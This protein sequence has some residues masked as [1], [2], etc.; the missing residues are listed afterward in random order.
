MGKFDHVA[1]LRAIRRGGVLDF[2]A[3]AVTVSVKSSEGRDD[4]LI[5]QWHQIV[6]MKS[7]GVRE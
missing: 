1:G 5:R 2:H 6:M 7:M 3:F 4:C